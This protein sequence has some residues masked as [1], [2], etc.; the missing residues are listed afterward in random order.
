MSNDVSNDVRN[1]EIFLTDAIKQVTE[2]LTKKKVDWTGNTP[3]FENFEIAT[4][5][6]INPIQFAFAMCRLK[7]NR[8]KNRFKRNNGISAEFLTDRDAEDSL[9]DLACYSILAL[10]LLKKAKNNSKTVDKGVDKDVDKI[11]DS[12]LDNTAV[13]NLVASWHSNPEPIKRYF[14]EK[15]NE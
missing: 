1:D 6:S 15:D 7:I 14:G 11:V 12:F 9:L 4:E 3:V 13:K 8:L 5:F 2:T 10:A